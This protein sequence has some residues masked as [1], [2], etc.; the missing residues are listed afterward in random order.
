MFPVMASRVPAYSDMCNNTA[1]M[2]SVMRAVTRHPWA[3][4]RGQYTYPYPYSNALL[5]ANYLLGIP[6]YVVFSISDNACLSY[7]CLLLLL[8]FV[9]AFAVYLLV[10]EWTGSALAGLVAGAM[11]AFFPHRVHD[12]VDY[13]YQQTF[14]AALALWA[15]LRYLHKGGWRSLLLFFIVIAVKAATIDY[16][17]VY[18]VYALALM[19][20]CG[21][22]AYPQ[23]LRE[24]WWQFVLMGLVLLA[25]VAP[26]YY[27]YYINMSRLPHIGWVAHLAGC[28]R[29]DFLSWHEFLRLWR[30]LPHNLVHLRQRATYIPDAP[31]LPGA[32]SISLSA[33]A[34]GWVSVVALLKG[35]KG[36]LRLGLILLSVF[37]FLLLVTPVF[38]RGESSFA[39]SPLARLLVDPPLLGFVRNS[40]AFIHNAMMCLALLSGLLVA[41]LMRMLQ[42][43]PVARRTFA[44]LVLVFLVLM[45]LEHTVRFESYSTTIPPRATGVYAWL[46]QQSHP[47]PFIEFP[48]ARDCNNFFQAM[49][50]VLADQPSGVAI[51]RSWPQMAYFLMEVG[52]PRLTSSKLA[53]LQ[54]SPYRFWVQHGAD[55]QYRAQ[56]EAQSDVRYATNFGGT[57]VFKNPQIERALPLSFALTQHWAL[58]FPH[59][60]MIEGQVTFT[61]LYSFVPLRERSLQIDL[62]CLTAAMK[63]LAR[64]RVRGELPF[65][66]AGPTNCFDVQ[67]RYDPRQ[68]RL[69]A[70]YRNSGHFN[71]ERWPTAHTRADAALLQT[72]WIRARLARRGTGKSATALLRVVPTPARWPLQFGTPMIMP[73]VAGE[74]GVFERQGAL[75][76]QRS[77]G[78]TSVVM[79]GRPAGVATALVVV[80]RAAVAK[81][82]APLVAQVLLN[83]LILGTISFD[84]AWRTNNLPTPENCWRD[85]NTIVLNYPRTYH[86]CLLRESYDT[87]RRCAALASMDALTIS[88][89]TAP[90]PLRED[91]APAK[92][93]RAA[94]APT[95]VV[96]AT[97][98]R[99]G[100]FQ[101]GLTNWLPWRAANDN[102]AALSV[103]AAPH[104]GRALQIANPQAQLLGL[105]QLVSMVSGTTYR[106]RA[107]ARSDGKD[108]RRIFGGRV[109]VYLPPEPEHE[110]VWLYENGAW[111]SQACVFTCQ[112]TGHAT[113][114]VHLGYGNVAATGAFTDIALEELRGASAANP[115]PASRPAGLIRATA[116]VAA[117]TNLVQRI[118]SNGTTATY[119]SIYAA[120][121]ACQNDDLVLI[122][123]GLY[124]E[125]NPGP[126]WLMSYRRNVRIRGIGWP[127]LEV[128]AAAPGY[129]ISLQLPHNQ[130]LMLENL[131]VHTIASAP[132]NPMLYGVVLTGGRDVSVSNCVFQGDVRAPGATF[133]NLVAVNGASNIVVHDSAVITLDLGGDARVMH[134]AAHDAAPPVFARCLFVGRRLALFSLGAA[135]FHACQAAQ[136]ARI[137]AD[138]I[139]PAT[140]AVISAAL[141]DNRAQ[142]LVLKMDEL[143]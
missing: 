51:G 109:A 128:H 18:L 27:P 141:M 8:F 103:I 110:L 67:M 142:P 23:R 82:P 40:R 60:Y 125:T 123:D 122:H 106:L 104:P 136:P 74:F 97:L 6:Y 68:R 91:S 42:R 66:L 120:L 62:E 102:P 95:P 116:A 30:T 86:P 12:L 127:L 88:T 98:V 53:M 52:N 124:R 70:Q 83:D 71:M 25:L 58:S 69:T 138:V 4:W 79:N 75:P 101:D 143:E 100:A 118:S 10:Y 84:T 131:R 22:L 1:E 108:A 32:L 99:N 13:H 121:R 115:P 28:T 132:T 26:L 76:F 119:T 96:S 35:R 57:Y 72:R 140:P 63:P 61:G 134:V 41:D 81:P 36:L 126:E 31:L 16:Q 29:L 49:N 139:A 50:G 92:V 65:M 59:I 3:L 43:W 33:L 87:S 38:K 7:N 21:Y 90:A 56:V 80:A 11:C 114:Y 9:N 34:L 73:H 93:A 64:L 46:E 77:Q 14:T 130:D 107:A 133:K 19:V 47:S 137:Q 54:A 17:T 105:Q 112:A 5:N 89:V 117:A 55:E 24:S 45:T 15:W 37:T 129:Q 44:A 135:K 111:S 39:L 20:P 94:P 85:N 78:A 2:L 113:L 48:F